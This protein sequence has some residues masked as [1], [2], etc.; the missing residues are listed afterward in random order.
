LK[1]DRGPGV[2]EAIPR[3]VQ[4]LGR[5]LDPGTLDRLWIFP[6]MVRGRKEWGLIAVS[7][8]AAEGGDAARR[9]LFTAPYA[10]ERTGKGLTLEWTL[11][12]QGE[13]PPDR[14][15]RVMDGVV[16]RA[17]DELG[18]PRA[19][20]LGGDLELFT[21]L[22]DELGTHLLEPDATVEVGAEAPA[23]PEPEPEPETDT[24][25][26]PAPEPAS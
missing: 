3:T 20:D 8:F 10:A 25:G 21:A 24:E 19:V 4:G 16:R 23:A 14:L 9:H 7:R 5:R 13:A 17:G 22:L 15:P 1:Q 2:P 26:E 12:E 18:D 11:A 6:P